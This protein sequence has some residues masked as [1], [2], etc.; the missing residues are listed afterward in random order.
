M[1]TGNSKFRQGFTR[2]VREVESFR[3]GKRSRNFLKSLL[4][5][6]EVGKTSY[7]DLFSIWDPSLALLEP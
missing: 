5:L 3:F 7:S 6:Q 2:E 1:D 4:T